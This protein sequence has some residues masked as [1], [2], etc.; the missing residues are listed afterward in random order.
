MSIIQI[1]ND[2]SNGLNNRVLNEPSYSAN[3]FR[4]PVSTQKINA[5]LDN[6][7]SY[8]TLQFPSDRPK[9]YMSMQIANYS[10]QSLLQL[11]TLTPRET[12]I[13]PLPTQLV[14]AQGVSYQ[15]TALGAFG[16]AVQ[17]VTN[18]GSL[19]KN[20]IDATNQL[21]TEGNL[22]GAFNKGYDMLKEAASQGRNTSLA[23]AVQGAAG[24]GANW[25]LGGSNNPATAV[26]GVL[27][28]SPNQFFTI[29]LKGPNY[30]KHQFSWKF[31]PRNEQESRNLRLIIQKLNNYM[32]PGL[33]LSGAIFAFPQIFQLAFMPNSSYMFKF[34][35][36]VLE[37]FVVNRAGAGMP[38]F[39]R[40]SLG[41]DNLNA[42]ESIEIQCSFMELEYWIAGDFKNVEDGLLGTGSA[43]GEPLNDP[44]DTHGRGN[45]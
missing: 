34:K 17:A 3:M 36:A 28:Y 29:L 19:M 38:A 18:D 10:R 44:L 8:D 4:A 32:A 15:E 30:K 13:L 43:I 9:Y 42:P 24:V 27:G 25:A 7:T 45:Y 1:I 21:V 11:G 33:R 20:T 22:P 23:G 2:Q 5:T 31:S 6:L 26:A 41:T 16:A 35:P 14:D 37:S 12:I 39:Y 40:A